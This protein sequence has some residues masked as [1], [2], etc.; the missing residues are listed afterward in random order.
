VVQPQA[1]PA[2]EFV[3]KLCRTPKMFTLHGT[4]GEVVALLTGAIFSPLDCDETD[5]A[6]KTFNYFVTSRLLVPSKFWWAGAIQMVAEDD[7]GAIGKLRDLL[8]EFMTLRQSMTLEDIRT[9]CNERLANYEEPAPA[10]VWRAFMAA[11]FRGDQATLE[12][13]ILPNQD[14][15]VLWQGGGAPPGVAE[16][17]VSLAD[18]NLVS[19][20][21]G[22]LESGSVQLVTEL[23]RIAAHWVDGGWKIDASPIITM[24]KANAKTS[25]EAKASMTRYSN[26]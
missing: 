15:A 16:Q 6:F 7:A 14:A 11:R 18:L 2:L 5:E 24:D 8:V 4:F 26:P 12:R 1:Y 17:L 3:E 10:K 9:D 13:L 23:G 20:A 21:T 22:T 25:G 19:I